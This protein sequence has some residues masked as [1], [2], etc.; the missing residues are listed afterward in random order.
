MKKIIMSETFIG[1]I[2]SIFIMILF[3]FAFLWAT[4]PEQWYAGMHDSNCEQ[5]AE[6]NTCN[7]YE[8]FL[9]NDPK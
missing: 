2:T 3:F 7:C 6:D 8:R 1:I 4:A 9:A 5:T